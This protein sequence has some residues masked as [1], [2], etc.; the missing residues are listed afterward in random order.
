MGKLIFLSSSAY[1]GRL[2]SFKLVEMDGSHE[3]MF[4]R[5]EELADKIVEGGQD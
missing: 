4:T 2:G 3:V 5:P 1:R